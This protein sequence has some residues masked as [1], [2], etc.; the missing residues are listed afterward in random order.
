MCVEVRGSA[1]SLR[2]IIPANLISV[3]IV[4]TVRSARW[5]ISVRWLRPSRHGWRNSGEQITD[6]MRRVPRPRNAQP[7]IHAPQTW[8]WAPFVFRLGSL[9]CAVFP[10][11]SKLGIGWM[12]LPKDAHIGLCRYT[13]QPIRILISVYLFVYLILEA[14]V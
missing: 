6:R 11:F 4:S 3:L 10:V 8:S 2:N 14:L 5:I 12:L 1:R 9:L 13:A 7:S